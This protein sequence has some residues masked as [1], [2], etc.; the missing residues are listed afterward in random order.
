[1]TEE[2]ILRM[3]RAK[4][5]PEHFDRIVAYYAAL[6][7]DPAP[8]LKAEVEWVPVQEQH[9]RGF[10][11]LGPAHGGEEHIQME[12]IIYLCDLARLDGRPITDEEAA[13][14]LG[15]SARSFRAMYKTPQ[16]IVSFPAERIAA[17]RARARFRCYLA[18]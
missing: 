4:L 14:I 15:I 18:S 6:G 9:R 7:V 1:M 3:A 5:K 17:F 11:R 10:P 2:E 16:R 13:E 12:S 8:H